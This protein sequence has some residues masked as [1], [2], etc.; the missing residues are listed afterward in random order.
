MYIGENSP[1]IPIFYIHVFGLVLVFFSP[2]DTLFFSF[3]TDF[4][5]IFGLRMLWTSKV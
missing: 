4:S 3:F 2:L 5:R 1:F